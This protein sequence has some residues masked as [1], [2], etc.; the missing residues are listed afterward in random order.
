MS[1]PSS[2][3]LRVIA[4]VAVLVLSACQYFPSHEDVYVPVP[5]R[6]GDVRIDGTDTSYVL[7][8][9]G[10]EVVAF[11]REV[12]LEARPE[13][14]GAAVAFRRHFG[15]DP[16]VV[17]IHYDPVEDRS[18]R[19]ARMQRGDTLPQP[20]GRRGAGEIRVKVA[21]PRERGD[22]LRLP[23]VA[24]ALAQE[25]IMAFERSAGAGATGDADVPRDASAPALPA[26]FR[27]GAAELIARSP[28]QTAHLSM[29][30]RQLDEAPAL[31]E[32]FRATSPEPVDTGAA[33]PPRRVPS[34]GMMQRLDQVGLWTAQSIAVTRYL[35]DRE[36]P[37]YIGTVAERLL[38]GEDILEITR[39][40][41]SLPATPGAL[42]EAWRAW[43]E[44][45]APPLRGGS[46]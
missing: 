3:A 22:P 15:T 25:W 32:F 16:R 28:R 7:T 39:S 1:H 11:A 42:D 20:T 12:L 35:A 14:E 5:L 4:P 17:R 10:Y 34:R 30:R 18:F 26:W 9:V 37:E 13:L 6:I 23:P 24:A 27:A 40:A 43:L 8:G 21:R 19:S 2:G 36:G 44:A 31:E 41:R 38:G 45:V 33:R 46:E 29:L